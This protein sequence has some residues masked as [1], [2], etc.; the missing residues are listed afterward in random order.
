MELVRRRWWTLAVSAAAL[1]VVTGALL[2]ASFQL[3]MLAA[4]GYRQDIADYVGRV[5]GEPVDIGGIG[6]V[7]TGLAPRLELTDITL[8]SQDSSDPALVVERLRLGF[9][10][11][12]LLRGDTTPQRVE[13]SGVQLHAV[14]DGEGR[15]SL[16]GID[17]AGR[18]S[19]AT[20]DWLR[21]L[22]RFESVRLSRCELQLD[23]ARLREPV[24]PFLLTEAEL[25]FADGRGRFSAE[26]ALPPSI[27][28]TVE[29]EAQIA[30]DLARPETWNGRW[31]AEVDALSG[32]P[33]INA[34][35]A[36]DAE[37]G[38][39]Q[40]ELAL[41]GVVSGGRLGAVDVRLDAGEIIGRRGAQ[42][43]AFTEI[44]ALARLT[45]QAEGWIADI[46]RLALSGQ[47]QRWPQS[48]VR[49][50]WR[51]SADAPAA[52]DI[53]A[54]YLRLE[55][56]LPWAALLPDSATDRL[57]MESLRRLSGELRGLVLRS[58]GPAT[59]P[60]PAPAQFALRAEIEQLAFAGG[61]DAATVAGL[62]GS[63]SASQSGGRLVLR[64]APLT[65]T[66]AK[67]FARPLPF[68]QVGGE[69]SWSRKGPAWQLRVP[70]FN[71]RF[72]STRGEGDLDLLL[73]DDA[74]SPVLRFDA[75]FSGTD[76]GQLKPYIPIRWPQT[77][78]WLER[79]VLGGRSPGG[80]LRIEGPVRGFPFVETAGLFALDIDVAEA[81]LQFDPAWPPVTQASAR[82]E[83]RGRSLSIRGSSAETGG[84]Q[85]GDF[86]VSIADFRDAQ[87]TVNADVQGD[88]ARFYDYLR[89]S[90]L[91]QDLD[92]LLSRTEAAGEAAVAL[93]LE[94]PLS[95][96]DRSIVRGNV[97]LR[98]VELTVK[99]IPEPIRALRGEL[100]FDR[101]GASG[102]GLSAEMFATPLRAALIL[103][104]LGV[105][106]LSA[107][108]E[109]A[110]DAA[111][112]GMSQLLPQFLRSHL[113]GAS[114]WQADLALEGGESG[115][116]E[117]A[118]DLRGLAS[119]LPR[120][121]D[122]RPE[123]VWPT[124][125]SLRADRDFA[126]RLGL[127]IKDQLGADLAFARTTDEK[128]ALQ[129][130]RLRLGAGAAPYAE[131][132]GVF[133]SGTVT[134]LEPLAWVRSVADTGD[135]GTATTPAAVNAPLHADLNVGTLWL[136]GQMLEGV[137]LTHAPTATGW[138]T[139][140]SGS[141]ARGELG[142]QRDAAGGS[143][144]GR[145]DH[146]YL[147]YRG[148]PGDAAVPDGSAIEPDPEAAPIEP[149]SLPLLDLR[150]ADFQLGTASLGQL[151]LRTARIADGQ[152]IEQFSTRGAGAEVSGS[153]QWRR[154]NGRSSAAL[155]VA[156][157]SPS[158]GE[159]LRGLGYAPSVSARRSQFDARLAWPAAA[160]GAAAGITWALAE[161]QLDL[162][163]EKGLLHAVEPGAGRVLGLINFW[164]LP[165]RLSLDFRDVVSEGLGF[166]E[167]SGS[168]ALAN[169]AALT[170]DLDID[171]PSLNIEVRGRVG[172]VARDYDQS[173]TV[174]PDVSA[175]ITLG[176]LLLGGPA[177][178][179]LAL[180]A[181][182]VLDQPL[183]QIGQ[184]SYR[185]T[186]G[187][188]DPQLVRQGAAE[189]PAPR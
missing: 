63:V 66:L 76:A 140:L 19:R 96:V 15:F 56:L 144:R 94:I 21:Q 18:P 112:G 175:G 156:A 48:R 122:K 71:W 64:E 22:G 55:D 149:Q 2:T 173:V 148:V 158:I 72:A 24:P 136:G 186:G 77:G 145:F 11:R 139:L 179:I 20:Q 1:L 29:L 114:Q 81:G 103:D 45:P 59:A 137:R 62:S 37:L 141:G 109:V 133:I 120:P 47:R 52:L 164:A 93:H 68:E 162:K 33:W 23:D 167:V 50:Q 75:K 3:V 188:D 151:E 40:T 57:P 41:D 171:A 130:A 102:S 31:S 106:R 16:R 14:I 32:L 9:G 169:G 165:R 178:G 154:V 49:V 39:R 54:D 170:D 12:R 83:F 176:A 97:S 116:L 28:S 87:L 61:P 135:A 150:V 13:L 74:G 36:S 108:F 157:S 44:T 38:F 89:A 126:L 184:L 78:A 4:P 95:D 35:L 7:W 143:V 8:Y 128:P 100:A 113:R 92:A 101:R 91:N 98:G 26:L 10:L 73:P 146:L 159:I 124:R 27:G 153:G 79:A 187:W 123:S 166:D 134:E 115:Q 110:V 163:L 67:V 107:Q 69:L 138:Q 104:D 142:F 105:Q 152:R 58:T 80:R 147:G 117:L 111:G 182:E 180:I 127:E 185:L 181:Q 25:A 88:A 183:D 132:D 17:S 155:Q 125:L 43:A 34:R 6:L 5:A 82:L 160:S 53:A 86:D 60:V 42:Q 70:R 129:R 118:S 84:A 177:A 46:D 85:V 119:S 131:A 168:F 90:P 65:L 30:G 189:P 121:L 51:R 174:Y 172:L 161:G 99:S